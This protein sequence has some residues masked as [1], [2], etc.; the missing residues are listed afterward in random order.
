MDEHIIYADMSSQLK[1]LLPAFSQ[2]SSDHGFSIV[3][4]RCLGR[5]PRARV[6][7]VTDVIVYFDLWMCLDA[8]GNRYEAFFET[9]PFDLGAGVYVDLNHEPPHG[10]RYGVAFPIWERRPFSS[11]TSEEMV[12]AMEQS[13]PTLGE[14]NVEKLKAN[15]QL[16]MLRPH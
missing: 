11:I 14:W 6:E 7:K 3:D 9:I 1:F 15:G 12:R 5:Y 8:E 4:S 13:L 16:S 2:F 10:R